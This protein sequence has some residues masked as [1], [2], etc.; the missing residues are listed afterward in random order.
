MKHRIL[1]FLLVVILGAAA[2]TA[3][4]SGSVESGDEAVNRVYPEDANVDYYEG[5]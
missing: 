2:L 1:P 4:H 5:E 3:C